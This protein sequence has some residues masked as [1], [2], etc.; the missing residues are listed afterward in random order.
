MSETS[1]TTCIR[2]K[3][4][5]YVEQGK[6]PFFFTRE[7][8]EE[9]RL[10]YPA[11]CSEELNPSVRPWVDV[12]AWDG[13]HAN[14]SLD[15][16]GFQ[17]VNCPTRLAVKDFYDKD[18]IKSVYYREMEEAMMRFTG[19]KHVMIFNHIVRNDDR[20]T[21]SMGHDTNADIQSFSSGVHSDTH[22]WSAERFYRYL[23]T[24]SGNKE[25]KQGAFIYLTGWRNILH[26][27]VV[28]NHLVLCDQNSLVVPDDF[29]IRDLHSYDED[30]QY[31]YSIPQYVLH[32]KNAAQHKWYYFPGITRD[33]L[34]LHKQYDSDTSKRARYAFHTSCKDP[35]A[36]A[37][38]PTRTSIEVRAMV[39]FPDHTPNTIP[40]ME[41]VEM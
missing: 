9:E 15:E 27:P 18:K 40:F 14:L 6:R 19:S 33:E 21:G 2:T 11:N 8:T 37:D 28:D 29:M 36:P 34:I 17:K 23:I 41:D 1:K 10:E 30:N 12:T 38:A 16:N 7:R 25:L 20:I 35:T 24:R 31:N 5:Y 26:T 22:P 3:V 13:T 32:S 39:A 4:R